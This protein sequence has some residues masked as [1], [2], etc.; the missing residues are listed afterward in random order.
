M[1]P[2]N[3]QSVAYRLT[4]ERVC[5][6]IT[7]DAPILISFL[8]P[9]FLPICLFINFRRKPSQTWFVLENLIK[10]LSARNLPRLT[11]L[12]WRKSDC[13]TKAHL[14]LGLEPSDIKYS[15]NSCLFVGLCLFRFN[16]CART[17]SIS[18]LFPTGTV[19]LPKCNR[20]SSYY[21]TVSY[22]HLTLPTTGSV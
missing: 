6:A 2:D 7:I 5:S 14:L 19:S 13:I 9:V 8:M 10:P 21:C 22:T 16:G 3:E 11:L 20:G 4:S 15:C 17:V 12:G 1:K 18:P